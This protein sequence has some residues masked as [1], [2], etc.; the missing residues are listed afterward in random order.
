[1]LVQAVQAMPDIEHKNVIFQMIDSINL[2]IAQTRENIRNIQKT[3]SKFRNA[4]TRIIKK[5]G[6]ECSLSDVLENVAREGDEKVKSLE[7]DIEKGNAMLD[8]LAGHEWK[9]DSYP[10]G[11]NFTSAWRGITWTGM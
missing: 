2:T 4:A 3:A 5:N 6:A 10:Q 8:I 7:F 9:V 11:N 1:M